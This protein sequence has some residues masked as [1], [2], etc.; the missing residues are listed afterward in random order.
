[1][2]RR[3][4]EREKRGVV[5][6]DGQEGRGEVGSGGENDGRGREGGEGGGETDRE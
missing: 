5:R 4:C 2:K 3:G 1:M 6:G